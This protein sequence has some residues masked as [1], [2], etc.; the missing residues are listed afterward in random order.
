M[1]TFGA[2]FSLVSYTKDT[3]ASVDFKIVVNKSIAGIS[4]IHSMNEEAFNFA[5]DELQ[6]GYLPNGDV[7]L[8][9]TDVDAFVAEAEQA[10]FYSE[11]S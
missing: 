7:A 9:T 1:S 3:M 5:T 11:L 6:L 2:L 4:I 10:F 8:D